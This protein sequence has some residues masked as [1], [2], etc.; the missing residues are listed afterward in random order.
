MPGDRPVQ[1]RA[2]TYRADGT[3]TGVDDRLAG[4]RRFDV[5]I[6][7]QVEPAGAQSGGEG[8]RHPL[9][10]TSEAHGNQGFQMQPHGSGTGGTNSVTIWNRKR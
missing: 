1:H 10:V 5:G 9:G 7:R 3:L 2:Y 8:R 6:M 4:S